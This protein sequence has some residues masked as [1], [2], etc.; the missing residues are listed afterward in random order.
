M[1]VILKYIESTEYKIHEISVIGN[2]NGYEAEKGKMSKHG[3]EWRFE[4]SLPSG[5]YYY[6]FLVNR[7]LLL[8]DPWNNLFE[9]KEGKELWSVLYINQKGLWLCNPEPYHMTIKCCELIGRV[10]LTEKIRKNT[11]DLLRMD[12]LKA[13]V[14]FEKLYGL[15][16]VTAA[17]YLPDGQLFSYEEKMVYTSLLHDRKEVYL[18]LKTKE[19]LKRGTEGIWNMILFFDGAYCFKKEFVVERE[20][21]YCN[22]EQKLRL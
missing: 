19:V 4:C 7:E 8:N 22:G 1:N 10:K 9:P 12:E 5:T 2:F 17:W 18:P 13:V 21:A 16:T 20:K 14:Y 3:K 15:H 11:L 6:R